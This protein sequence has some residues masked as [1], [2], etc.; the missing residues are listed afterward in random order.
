MCLGVALTMYIAYATLSY[1]VLSCKSLKSWNTTPILLL[2]YGIRFG[3]KNVVSFP[4]IIIL[5]DVGSSSFSINFI[6]VDFPLPDDP[7]K[8]GAYLTITAT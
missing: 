4:F 2:K 7:T 1:T 3:F 8:N 5:P 6:S